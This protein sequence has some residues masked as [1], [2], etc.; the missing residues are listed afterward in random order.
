MTTSCSISCGSM[1]D[2]NRMR[3][4]QC[5]QSPAARRRLCTDAVHSMHVRSRH[6]FMLSATCLSLQ[7]NC[8][9]GM[10]QSFKSTPSTYNCDTRIQG[11]QRT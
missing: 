9:R 5:G 4:A 11:E 1:A 10:V 3:L 8:E 7:C 6:S 2:V